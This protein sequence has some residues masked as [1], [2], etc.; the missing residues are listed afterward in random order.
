MGQRSNLEYFSWKGPTMIQVPLPDQFRGC[1]TTSA[2]FSLCL[3]LF[4]FTWGLGYPHPCDLHPRGCMQ[5]P[6]PGVWLTPLMSL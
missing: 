2:N 4:F 5:P 6:Q 3:T 1:L